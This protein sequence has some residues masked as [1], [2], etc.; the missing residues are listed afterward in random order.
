MKKGMPELDFTAT[1]CRSHYPGYYAIV[2]TQQTASTNTDAARKTLTPTATAVNDDDLHILSFFS[3]TLTNL[4]SNDDNIEFH[5]SQL[6]EQ[7]EEI[8]D[9]ALFPH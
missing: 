5:S 8:V 3:P 4:N 9:V 7:Q 6:A 2:S 1:Y